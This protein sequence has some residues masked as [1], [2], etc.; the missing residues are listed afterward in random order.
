MS[1]T[2]LDRRVSE[3]ERLCRHMRTELNLINVRATQTPRPAL[4]DFHRSQ[5]KPDKAAG[6][7][8]TVTAGRQ[9]E[10]RYAKG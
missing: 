1:L 3:L 5:T 10:K 4:L 2:K 8:F 7:D 9:T 6:A